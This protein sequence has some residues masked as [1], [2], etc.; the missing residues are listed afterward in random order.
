MHKRKQL[1]NVSIMKYLTD[2][3]KYQTNNQQELEKERL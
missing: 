1:L 3:R 2:V